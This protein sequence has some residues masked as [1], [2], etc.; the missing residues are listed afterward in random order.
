MAS[1][2]ALCAVAARQRASASRS[3][4]APTPPIMCATSRRRRALSA[5]SARH[6]VSAERA[7]YVLDADAIAPV[8]SAAKRPMCT[9]ATHAPK[10]RRNFARRKPSMKLARRPRDRRVSTAHTP[11]M[12][13]VVR[14]SNSAAA[15]KIS[16][17]SRTPWRA[18]AA[19]A[20]NADDARQRHACSSAAVAAARFAA[21][22]TARARHAPRPR[23]S[24]AAARCASA[25]AAAA[26]AARRRTA[27]DASASNTARR[28][29]P[30]L[31]SHPVRSSP[32]STRRR[33]A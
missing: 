1:S 18:L 3:A 21:D 15:R 8:S 19:H 17:R 30:A 25:A 29:A 4:R 32:A 2:R 27:Y 20:A 23:R 14:P 16:P 11:K 22:A 31:R 6:A 24:A 13:R 28:R 33:A 10:L 12:D 7:T 26:C 5:A 9:M